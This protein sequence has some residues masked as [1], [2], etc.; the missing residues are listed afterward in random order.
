MS[1]VSDSA[2]IV[3][4]RPEQHVQRFAQVSAWKGKRTHGTDHWK[5][6]RE[7]VLWIQG[8]EGD[9]QDWSIVNDGVDGRQVV[10]SYVGS[11]YQLMPLSIWNVT[12]INC[13]IHSILT[14]RVLAMDSV[15]LP[16][17]VS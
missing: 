14:T 17:W 12:L 9:M 15:L 1:Y 13:N 4:Y 10:S 8:V 16:F 6:G 2:I 3:R 11:K 7:R 5:N